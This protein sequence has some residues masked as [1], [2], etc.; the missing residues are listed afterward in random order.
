VDEHR[1]RIHDDLRGILEGE[2][3][4]D[5][6][7]RAAYALDA[8]LYEIDPLGVIV[9]RTEAD[10]V[11]VVRY[12][13]ENGI[14][15]HAR[16]AGSGRAGGAIGPGLVIDFSRYFR[17]I[18]D[19][20]PDRVVVQPGVVLDVL[21]A[22][23]AP[24][25]RRIGPDPI[26]AG[27][28]TIGGMVGHDASGP[29]SLRYGSTGDHVERL[30]V[31]FAGGELADLGLEF[32]PGFD[33]EP[34]D[35]KGMIVRKLGALVRRN[36]DLLVRKAP[37]SPRNGAGYALA[38]AASGMG[39]HLPRLI[40][41]SEGTLALVTEI[42][43]RTVPIAPAQAGVLLPFARIAD[44]AAVA[45]DC[46]DTSPTAC[47]LYDWRSIALVRELN[48]QFREWITDEAESILVLHFEG[49]NPE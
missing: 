14:A 38:K 12:A 34:S 26:G 39:I 17:Q 37:R 16:G 9:P 21:N 1:A 41:G 13:S 42:T 29:C 31:V 22:Q 10:V 43:L 49:D 7:E 32:W 15:I 20:Q 45:A 24:L 35:L 36:M 11:N 25:G 23:L 2:L 27:V 3:L 47:D 8:S 28:G 18:V 46:L 33:D 40:V 48:P 30:R 6:L 19:V 4:F 5:P 44:A